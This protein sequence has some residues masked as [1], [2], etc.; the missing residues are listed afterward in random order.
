MKWKRIDTKKKK[1]EVKAR[2][3][4]YLHYAGKKSLKLFCEAM[5]K[6]WNFPVKEEEYRIYYYDCLYI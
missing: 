2:C 6:L 5:Q 1:S 4:A 3:G